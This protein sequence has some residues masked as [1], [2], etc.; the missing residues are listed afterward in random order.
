MS[1]NHLHDEHDPFHVPSATGDRTDTTTTTRCRSASTATIG[2]CVWATTNT[3]R[4]MR[5]LAGALP[6]GAVALPPQNL[7]SRYESDASPRRRMWRCQRG[8]SEPSV[9]RCALGEGLS[10]DDEH[11]HGHENGAQQLRRAKRRSATATPTT[12][13]TRAR[14]TT[15]DSCAYPFN[16]QGNWYLGAYRYSSKNPRPLGQVP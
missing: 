13:A 15:I 7:Q 2:V 11:C 9:S 3:T 6:R 10:D 4:T 1:A 8:S 5:R 14:R 12:M 16:R